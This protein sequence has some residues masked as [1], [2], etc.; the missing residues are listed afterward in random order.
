MDQLKHYIS[1]TCIS[2]TFSILFF[3]LFSW[4]VGHL[5]TNARGIGHSNACHFA[6]HHH[7][8]LHHASATHSKYFD[9]TID[10]IFGR[11]NRSSCRWRIFQLISFHLVYYFIRHRDRC[12]DLSCCY[13]R[14]FYGESIKRDANQCD[15]QVKKRGGD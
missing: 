5:F 6:L 12:F 15:Y 2:F 11:R 3:L 13:H 7:S 9:F 8:Y 1:A 14:Y 4:L 10:Q